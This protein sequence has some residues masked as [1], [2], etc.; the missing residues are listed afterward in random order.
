MEYNAKLI[1]AVAMSSVI[2]AVL[3]ML[4][5]NIIII[6]A[7]AVLFVILLFCSYKFI[8][9]QSRRQLR[10]EKLRELERY[11]DDV[12][13]SGDLMLK[14]LENL[15]LILYKLCEE[16][17]PYAS[18]QDLFIVA[19]IQNRINN[20][21][22]SWKEYVEFVNKEC[23]IVQL[24]VF[25]H[26][27]KYVEKLCSIE[28]KFKNNIPRLAKK[29][30]AIKA[31]YKNYLEANKQLQKYTTDF[32]KIYAI[33]DNYEKKILHYISLESKGVVKYSLCSLKESF[34]E[35][36]ICGDKIIKTL[37]NKQSILS[38]LEREIQL[39][40]DK[41]ADNILQNLQE[42]YK[43]N[44]QWWKEYIE[45]V[46]RRYELINVDVVKKRFKIVNFYDILGL[47]LRMFDRFG[48]IIKKIL[49][50]RETS[51]ITVSTVLEPQ[52]RQKPV[53]LDFPSTI[54]SLRR[55][56]PTIR[57]LYPHYINSIPQLGEE[58]HDIEKLYYGYL[59]IG[60][61]L[62]NISIIFYRVRKILNSFTNKIKDNYVD[63][64]EQETREQ[65]DGIT[66]LTM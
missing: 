46:E 2:I 31:L 18:E 32:S 28:E 57:E 30:F 53:L 50:K 45:S 24:K 55:M 20:E 3:A 64:T 65:D 26:E 17:K 23:S 42:C 61:S 37:E 13:V 49:K 5:V 38:N 16:I 22:E 47:E 21:S 6:S 33:C 10:K 40:G 52:E 63:I 36:K 59:D 7:L 29:R 48:N 58:E 66:V 1:V 41:G 8:S 25:K 60:I 43:N 54:L 4:R 11:V 35:L 9:D 44:T 51:E 15:K 27:K 39:C 19:M 56:E 14:M 62:T 12:K 34:S